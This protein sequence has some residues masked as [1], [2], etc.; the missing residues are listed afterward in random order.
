LR[1]LLL[2]LVCA[3]GLWAGPAGELG[4]PF[5]RNFSHRD[6]GAA[7]QNWAIADDPR[8][9]IFVGNNRGV[10]EYDGATWRLIPTRGK[11]VVRSLGVDGSGRVYVGARNEF[12]Y[13]EPDAAGRTRYVPLEDLVDP[14]QRRFGDVWAALPTRDGVVFSTRDYLFTY[15]GRSIRS[16]KSPNPMTLAWKVRGRVYFF[17]RGVGPMVMGPQGPEPLPGLEAFGKDVANFVI[18]WGGG[19]SVLIG[20]PHHGLFLHDG[21]RIQ[22]FPTEADPYLSGALVSC[23]ALLSDG[24]LALGTFFGGCYILDRQ[25]R[26]LMHLDRRTGLQEDFVNRIWQDGSDRLWLALNR[27][28]TRVE[29]PAPFTSFR[30]DLGLDGS[31]SALTRFD[32]ALYA[33]TAKGLFRLEREPAPGAGAE[34][35]N[36]GFGPLWRFRK[37]GGYAGQVWN[38]LPY[39]GRLLAATNRGVLD[40]R[41]TRPVQVLF[42]GN[43]LDALCLLPSRRDPGR[44]YVGLS[45]GVA[46]LRFNGRTFREEA[47][48]NN[49][50][51]EVRSLAEREDGSLWA[52]TMAAGVLRIVPPGR[53]G[54]REP[55]VERFGTAQGL[56]SQ[57]HAFV[58]VLGGA[59]VVTTH[60]GVYRFND[61]SGRFEPDPR[62]STVGGGRPFYA[63]GVQE[64]AGGRV[65]MHL[66]D[67]ATNIRTTGCALPGPGG[68]Y[69]F[70]SSAWARVADMAQYAILPEEDAVWMGGPEGLIRYGI[71][72]E[73][74]HAWDVPPLVRRV[75]G[76]GQQVLFGGWGT[77]A[78]AGRLPY[79]RNTLR[80][81]FA[82][83]LGTP[84]SA[85]RYQVRLEGYDKDWSAWSTET[86][87]DYTNLPEGRY[88]FQ[89]RSRDALGR[90]SPAAEVAFRILPP[91]YR[92]WWAYMAYLVALAGL[93]Q[94]VVQWRLG[95]LRAIRRMLVRKVAERTEQLRR[96]TVQLEQAKA[97]AEA[98]TRAK[99]E[100]LANMSHEIRT[101]L[102]TILGY[103][104]I[105]KD[106]MGPTRHRD[107][108]EAIASGG[109]ALLGVI[110]D[111]LDLSKIE[112]GRMEPELAPTSPGDLAEEVLRTFSLRCREKG[113]ASSLELD[114]ALPPVLLL[115]QVHVRQILFNLVGNAVKFTEHGAIRVKVRECG[116]HGDRVDLA[117]EVEDTGIGIPP[118]QLATIFEAFRQMPGQDVARYGGTGLGLAICRRLA[119]MMQGELT[120]RSVVDQGSTFTLTIPD[121][122]VAPENAAGAE[123]RAVFRGE[124]QPATVLLV[125]DVQG[126]RD[127][128][129]DFF[130]A[131]PLIFLDASNGAE[132]ITLAR[133][134]RPALIIMDLRM[135]VMDGLEATRAL[136]ADP[137]LRQIPVL[138]MTASTTMADEG[139]VWASGAD[140]FLRKPVSR[141][142]LA[143]EMARFLT[144]APETEAPQEPVPEAP[145]PA[146][147][148][149]LPGLLARIDPATLAEWTELKDAFFID[150]M[151]AFA[152]RIGTL[153]ETYQEPRLAAWA[154][155][156]S[157]EAASFDM[158]SLPST[159][160]SFSA[161]VED[162][163]R[164]LPAG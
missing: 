119:A 75:L 54:P 104:E 27:G 89:V 137:G 9:I 22:P 57:L 35:V 124:F 21:V 19:D 78:G 56:P 39:R 93:A 74:A 102:N 110:G 58:R 51:A 52:G 159:F 10:L 28:V 50:K 13:L 38:L 118:S 14:G 151:A 113:L 72:Q 6:Y 99:S 26:L 55:Q 155:R 108:L 154:E 133:E 142:R 81:E 115:S 87:R 12:G 11:T 34:D 91:F 149:D 68:T 71:G 141:S 47:R 44:I 41:G 17:Q 160:R 114:P 145:A 84:E 65:W 129:R 96:R 79:A 29:W 163:R 111:I 95:R 49:L 82:A 69:R 86:F 18:P 20:T 43:D 61:T 94:L 150:R 127:L 80:F 40:F 123:V 148:A 121:L 5:L 8:G 60:G 16:W 62:F 33:G 125:D 162:L 3:L 100:F 66:L 23:G 1:C 147:C 134:T 152:V 138:I 144:L 4:M 158:E 103:A 88:R 77:W 32:G 135:P 132:A 139:P 46:A 161:V 116:R 30:E 105:L 48:W 2:A 98:A 153:A 90:V 70:E 106:E 36:P 63:D 156:V 37:M 15:D 85:V 126:N 112:A 24:N 146:P 131:S 42:S 157:V 128:V 67:E 73:R 25:G 7:T 109:K 140:A 64:D 31:V 117:I 83:P 136:K 101:P 122:A 120:V 97:E 76:P 107:H 45:T 130:D 143:A 59:A 164:G 92:K 53:G